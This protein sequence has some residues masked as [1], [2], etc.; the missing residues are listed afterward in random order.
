MNMDKTLS[1]TN[2]R[3]IAGVSGLAALLLLTAATYFLWPVAFDAVSKGLLYGLML[4]SAAMLLMTS[5]R[6]LKP[7]AALGV[8]AACAMLLTL[9]VLLHNNL[10]HLLICRELYG[11]TQT[12]GQ[13]LLADLRYPYGLRLWRYGGFAI[14]SFAVCAWVLARKGTTE[15]YE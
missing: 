9:G 15:R 4:V 10:L 8:A 13:V 14:L 2:I 12:F 11:E 6:R 7:A 1:K 3:L 5:P